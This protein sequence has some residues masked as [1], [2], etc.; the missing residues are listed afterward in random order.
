[1]SWL[2]SAKAP[3]V[4]SGGA[5]VFPFKALLAMH[6]IFA[7]GN[8]VRFLVGGLFELRKGNLAKMVYAA[9]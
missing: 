1:M 6:R 8:Q 9:D 7:P 4:D 2:Y 3:S 5:F